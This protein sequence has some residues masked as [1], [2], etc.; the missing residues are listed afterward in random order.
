MP[1]TMWQA[2]RI[3]RGRKGMCVRE[4]GRGNVRR[5]AHINRLTSPAVAAAIPVVGADREAPIAARLVTHAAIPLALG[6]AAPPRGR[7]EVGARVGRTV[8]AVHYFCA[9]SR[10]GGGRPVGFL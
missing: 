6:R 2:G 8:Q 4:K 5:D 9:Y 7:V 10:G 3:G 1:P